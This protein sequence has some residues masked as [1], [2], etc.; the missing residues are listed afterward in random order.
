MTEI[1][2]ELEDGTTIYIEAEDTGKSGGMQRVGIT[3]PNKQQDGKAVKKFSDALQH[4]RPA[5]EI[6][7]NT[8]KEMNTPYS[9]FSNAGQPFFM[10]N[11]ACL[12]I[13]KP[14]GKHPPAACDDIKDND[15]PMN[16]I[17]I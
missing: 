5:A 1:P 9:L 16:A 6:L 14:H 17:F 10:G 12:N 7:L 13:F 15:G 3:D 8:F 2:F 4:I 11:L